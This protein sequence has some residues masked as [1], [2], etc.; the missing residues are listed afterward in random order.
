MKSKDGVVNKTSRGLVKEL[1][2]IIYNLTAMGDR[3]LEQDKKDIDRSIEIIEIVNEL[4]QN[5]LNTYAKD[6]DIRYHCVYKHALKV[7]GQTKAAIITANRLGSHDIVAELLTI[8]AVFAK[9]FTWITKKYL[10][11][12]SDIDEFDCSRCL[13]DFVLGSKK[14]A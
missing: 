11:I 8:Y 12:D 13:D 7:E 3:L 14:A 6:C 5:I 10:K 4:R 2:G 9:V 1:E